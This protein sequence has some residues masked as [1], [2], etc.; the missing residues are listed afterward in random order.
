MTRS[1]K[2]LAIGQR[3]RNE[4][5]LSIPRRVPDA[6]HG[7]MRTVRG[8]IVASLAAGSLLVACSSSSSDAGGSSAGNPS[9]SPGA[10][11]LQQYLDAVNQLCDGLLPK[12]IRVTN[13]GSLDI[14][15]KQFFKQLP[16]HQRLRGNF[17]RDL[18]KIPVP[19]AAKDAAAALADY[20]AFAN[21]LDAKRLRAARKGPAAYRREIRSELRS[22]ADD[23]SIAARN[24][25][26]FHD[27][28]DAR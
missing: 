15:L 14:P 17:D 9:V 18:A 24:T 25:A 8:A 2:L 20:L 3:K 28:C 16:A 1:R 10:V 23:P 12:V 13:G 7:V 6:Q 27:S 19:P 26:G 11:A 22:A 21:Q 5:G 4:S